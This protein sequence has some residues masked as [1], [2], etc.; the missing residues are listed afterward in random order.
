MVR[1]CL[2]AIVLTLLVSQ[3]GFAQANPAL[4]NVKKVY[5]EKMENNLDQYI[6]SEISKQFRGSLKGLKKAIQ[7]K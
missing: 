4:F 3:L 2:L 1:R 5:V 7:P 6:T